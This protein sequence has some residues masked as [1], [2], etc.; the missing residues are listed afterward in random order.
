VIRDREDREGLVVVAIDNRQKSAVRSF[1]PPGFLLQRDLEM[2][3]RLPRIL[4]RKR[5]GRFG[6][7]SSDKQT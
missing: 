4:T 6:V 5:T 3:V 1:H 2:N 7:S